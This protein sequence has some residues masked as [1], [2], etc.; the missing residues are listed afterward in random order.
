RLRV[1]IAARHRFAEDSLAAAV[2]RGVAQVVVL[3][4]GLD[5]FAYRNPFAGTRVFEVDFPATGVWKRERLA[6]A[7]I[8]VP[9]SVA[10]VGVDFETDDLVAR[11]VEAGFDDAAPAF[12]VWLGVVP[13]LTEEAVTTT[14]RSIASVPGAEVVLDYTNPAHELRLTAQGDRADLIARVAEVGEPLSPGLEAEHLHAVL[15]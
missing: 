4:A 1:F 15:S 9:E 7:G 3:G 13:Y 14:L 10:Y 6:D 8:E 12:F 5:T 11:L 2:E